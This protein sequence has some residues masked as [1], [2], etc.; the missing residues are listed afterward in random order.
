MHPNCTLEFY[1]MPRKHLTDKAIKSLKTTLP[2]E[3]FIDEGFIRRGVTFGV[4]VNR[5][6]TKEYFVRYRDLTKRYRRISLGDAT[7]L[8][9][10]A[11]RKKVSELVLKI[12][13]GLDPA[14]ERDSY[15]SA[16]TFA[17]LC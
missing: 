14:Y 17:D 8:S 5:T 12:A 13:E 16:I 1:A 15:K 3:D 4:R 11:A 6:G 10:S 7:V 9:L 2:Q